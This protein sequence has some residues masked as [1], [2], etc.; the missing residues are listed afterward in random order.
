M[1]GVPAD[2]LASSGFEITPGSVADPF[3]PNAL[4]FEALART[5][6]PVP[7][8]RP[9]LSDNFAITRRLVELLPARGQAA[10]PG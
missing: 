4:A 1:S 7:I 5:I 6:A 2:M 8:D 9:Q 10:L 3:L